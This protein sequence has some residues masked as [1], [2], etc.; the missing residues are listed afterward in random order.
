MAAFFGC[1]YAGGL[2]FHFVLNMFF[3]GCHWATPEL[4]LVS[5]FVMAGGAIS[6][7]PAAQIRKRREY[8]ASN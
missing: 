6:R 7:V 8:Y 5:Q 4:S 3:V 1:G 2:S